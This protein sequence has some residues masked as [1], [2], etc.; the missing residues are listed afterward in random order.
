MSPSDHHAC[1]QYIQAVLDRYRHTPGVLGQVRRADRQL[2]QRLYEDR[3]PFYVI[4]RACILAA[5]RRIKNNAFSTPLPPIRSLHYFL[6]II[7][8]VIHRPPGPRDIQE[9]RALL[10]AASS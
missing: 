1:Q 2:A 5:A 7:H 8:E 3:V 6:P 4:D 10:H 9:M